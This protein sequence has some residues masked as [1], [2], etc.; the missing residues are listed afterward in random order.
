MAGNEPTFADLAAPAAVTSDLVTGGLVQAGDVL[1][2]WLRGL[3]AEVC[4]H[5][6]ALNGRA[7]MSAR[8]PGGR[9]IELGLTAAEG[10]EQP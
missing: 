10:T 7:E 6:D 3:G 5:Y 8:W 9:V 4:I 2:T 1:R